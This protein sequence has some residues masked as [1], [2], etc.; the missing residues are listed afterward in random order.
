MRDFAFSAA[1]RVPTRRVPWVIDEHLFNTFNNFTNK[2]GFQPDTLQELPNDAPRRERFKIF[3]WG[4]KIWAYPEDTALKTGVWRD[5]RWKI[6]QIFGTLIAPNLSQY[7]K[8]SPTNCHKPN[9]LLINY[10]KTNLPGSNS[11]CKY[12]GKYRT[13]I[14]VKKNRSQQKPLGNHQNYFWA[15]SDYLWPV[16]QSFEFGGAVHSVPVRFVFFQSPCRCEPYAQRITG[17]KAWDKSISSSKSFL[18]F[19]E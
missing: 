15:K 7:S 19:A 16:L 3:M 13:S 11:L 6:L 5:E 14:C 10:P 9:F 12:Q 1:S 8:T 18:L 17:F 2:L 4:Q